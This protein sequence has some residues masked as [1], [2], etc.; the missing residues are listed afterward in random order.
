M[1]VNNSAL[2]FKFEPEVTLNV[3]A[4]DGSDGS[5]WLKVA[6]DGSMYSCFL[7]SLFLVSRWLPLPRRSCMGP[8]Y[9]A[10]YMAEFCLQRTLRLLK[11]FRA[12][13]LTENVS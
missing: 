12:Q 5:R 3:P 1:D 9:G 13:I 7:V 8:T 11:M 10:L 4:T 6:Q 2:E